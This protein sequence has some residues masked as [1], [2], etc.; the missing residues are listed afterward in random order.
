MSEP[1]VEDCRLICAYCGQDNGLAS[2]VRYINKMPILP[3]CKCGRSIFRL[4]PTPKDKP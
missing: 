2:K 3:V 1:S 4:S